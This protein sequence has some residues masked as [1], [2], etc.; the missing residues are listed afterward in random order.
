MPRPT[1]YTA[2]LAGCVLPLLLASTALAQSPATLSVERGNNSLRLL[3]DYDDSVADR[4]PTADVSVEHTVLIARLSEPLDADVASLVGSLEG[5]AARARL[6]P[7]GS[8]LRIAL[9]QTVD[10]YTSASY[11]QVAIDFVPVGGSRP[12]DIVSPR[13]A[14]EIEAA[15]LAAEQAAL[16]PP[17]PPPAEA[18]PVQYRVGQ[19]TEY[20]RIEL[21]W[22]REVD[23]S[24]SQ[25][26]DV[27]EVRFAEPADIDL[28]RLAGSPPRFLNGLSATRD[29]DEFVLTLDVEPGVQVRAWG[30]GGRVAI[31]LP[32]PAFADAETLLA[33]IEA[34]AGAQIEPDEIASD[35]ERQA[36]AEP[37]AVPRPQR[38]ATQSA[39]EPVPVVAEA[40]PPAAAPADNRPAELSAQPS[41]GNPVPADGVVQAEVSDF[42]GDLRID[43]NWQAPL[44]M[45][46]FRR[47]EAVWVVFD[48]AAELDLRELDGASRRHIRNFAGVNGETYSAARLIVPAT[49]QAEA[50]LDGNRWTVV[51]SERIDAPP[52]PINV[53]RDA[54]RGRPGRILMDMSSAHAI[55][56][57][58]DP[59]VGDMI[60][61]ITALGPIQGLAARSE[62]VGGALLPSAQGGA[63]Q[64]I[65]EDIEI[66]LIGSGAAISRPSGLNLTPAATAGR[67]DAESSVLANI[68][69]PALMYFD[70]W[71]GTGPY[72]DEWNARLRRTALEDGTDGQIALARF[73]LARD[74]APEALGMAELA[75]A[76]EPQLVD[77][78][79]VRSLQAVA[80]YML[81]RPED[82][83]AYL[84]HASLAQDPAADLWRAMVAVSEERWQDARRRFNT[85]EA[86]VYHYPPEWQ[87]RFNAAHARAALE[88]GDTAAA[89]DY[90]YAV[91]AGDPDWRTRLDARYVAARVA[92]ASGNRT[93]AIRRFEELSESGHPESEARALFDLYRLQLDEGVISRTVAIEN[94]ENLRFRWRGDTIELETVRTLGELYVQAGDFAGGLETM[95]TA[96]ARFPESEAGRRI[97]EDMV[98]I[99][100]RLFLDGEAD[101]MDPVEAVA[102]FYQYQ[103]LAPIGAD[104]DR[105]IRRLADRLI[106]FD[107]LDPAAEL[108]QHQVDYR[109]REPLARARVAT[110][111]AIV[112]LMDRRYEDALNTIRRSRIAG[113]PEVLVD[114]RYLL[115][116]R[117]LSELGRS[118]Q[119]LELIAS[120]QSEAASRLR[121]DVAWTQRDWRNAGRR[122]EGILGNRHSD[123]APLV[124]TEEDD[125]L[126]AAIAYSLSRDTASAVRLGQR[127]GEAMA[128]TDQ[129]AAFSLL[130][131]DDATPGNVRFSDMASRI[132]SIDTLD[133]FMEPFRARFVNG[134]GPS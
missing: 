4:L 96:Q 103:H 81:H 12:A 23:V 55:R 44:G 26:G 80:S 85:G 128:Q 83:S 109:L 22:P 9:N 74:L 86:T 18:L 13:E 92:E 58:D 124:P 82:A 97:G 39:A 47:G 60:G 69:S 35:D 93:E 119:A 11:D 25:S 90:L 123:P 52:R 17:P 64:A 16:P 8:T 31:D 56:W 107:L 106:A 98:S 121:A 76:A 59:V 65:A 99:F 46:V 7:D 108:L 36:E 102:I 37:V 89:Q 105:M 118:D 48:A 20:T 27:A 71:R 19:A 114:E 116:A 101:R 126:R 75:V 51:L 61:V 62:F 10:A 30:E 72:L 117:A 122:L 6:D 29:G 38:P 134:G 120:D 57:I 87:A 14:R 43:F 21:L 34:A 15:R 67:V 32:D 84:S 68:S 73:L 94:L 115:E 49:S 104:G 78:P 42:N 113:L 63:V 33:Q 88:L 40:P 45:A 131:D 91:E 110:D 129:A 130:T 41:G 66:T 77:D 24:V 125:L 79:H 3:I 100:R 2:G 111:L 132:A 1:R 133:A 5:L 112:Y 53:R 95:A 50:R 127:Y 70:A 54:R 28:S